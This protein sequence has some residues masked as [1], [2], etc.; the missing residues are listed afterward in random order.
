MNGFP[1]QCG[2]FVRVL[3]WEKLPNWERLWDESIQEELRVRSSH[4]SQSKVEEE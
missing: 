2:M 3:A 4:A 1:K